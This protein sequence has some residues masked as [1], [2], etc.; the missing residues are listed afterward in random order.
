MEN[1]RT[2]FSL[3]YFFIDATITKVKCTQITSVKLTTTAY[4]SQFGAQNCIIVEYLHD[5]WQHSVARP[6]KITYSGSR[7]M[8]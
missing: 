5:L 7:R 2:A 3:K 8:R 6:P 4:V 1:L